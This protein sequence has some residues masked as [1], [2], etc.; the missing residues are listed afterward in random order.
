MTSSAA[1]SSAQPSA[2]TVR[3]AA[4]AV[5][6]SAMSSAS[7]GRLGI[8]GTQIGIIALISIWADGLM[9]G[10]RSSP[11]RPAG[12]STRQRRGKPDRVR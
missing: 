1:S 4:R 10:H 8:P 6:I 9:I 2:Q 11:I 7:F 5:S 12:Q 3:S